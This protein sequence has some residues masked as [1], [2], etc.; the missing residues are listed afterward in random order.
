MLPQTKQI[1]VQSLARLTFK[2]ALTFLRHAFLTFF[3]FLLPLFLEKLALLISTEAVKL[4][5]TLFL[6]FLLL[7]Q[8]S[9]LGLFILN[10]A[11]KFSDLLF[12]GGS[13]FANHLGA[14]VSGG[15]K[16]IGKVEEV[17]E[18]RKG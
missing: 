13:K 12:A 14:E 4:G 15:N 11:L 18:E 5:L 17:S 6:L 8:R 16:H 10:C 2:S 3:G 7:L 9:L 1:L